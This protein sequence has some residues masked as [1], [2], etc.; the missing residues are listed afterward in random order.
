[1]KQQK[2]DLQN[3]YLLGGFL[4]QG[5]MMGLKRKELAEL[6]K[7][8][9]C[10][11]GVCPPRAQRPATS[12]QGQPQRAP[13]MYDFQ[14]KAAPGQTPAHGQGR[15][16][17]GGIAASSLGENAQ[18]QQ[19][20]KR[21]NSTPTPTLPSPQQTDAGREVFTSEGRLVYPQGGGD[22]Y[23]VKGFQPAAQTQSN[24]ISQVNRPRAP[25][26]PLN[27]AQQPQASPQQAPMQAGPAGNSGGYQKLRGWLPPQMEQELNRVGWG[28]PQAAQMIQSFMQKNPQLQKTSEESYLG[29]AREE[30]L[31]LARVHNVDAQDYILEVTGS[32]A[33]FEK[34]A[35]L[36][37]HRVFHGFVDSMKEHGANSDFV[38]GF[39]KEAQD[40]GFKPMDLSKPMT[41]TMAG[42][43]GLGLG[44][45]T[46][47]PNVAPLGG[48]LGAPVS[49]S[50]PA[51]Q[52][53]QSQPT[54]Q[55]QQN[56]PAPQSSDEPIPNTMPRFNDPPAKESRHEII[57][58]F[59]N[60][61]TGGL[62]GMLLGSFIG[63]EM[64]LDGPMGML[65][66]LLGAGAGYH[67]LPKLMNKWKDPAGTGANAIHP[68]V[69]NMNQQF[70]HSL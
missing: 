4:K 63:N 40:N 68:A 61:W 28:T 20:I 53:Q 16:Y 12:N 5:E 6:L 31:K 69:Q 13:S 1:M 65:L 36:E 30:M 25:Y 27:P 35:A 41:N 18:M 7:N 21:M 39:M 54:A 29:Y 9:S 32:A 22:P 59:N 23:F 70:G 58:G 2:L 17:G 3:P 24:N 37:A 8:A 44:T 60:K 15:S 48:Q 49:L 47:A 51:P 14:T 19:Q 45:G 55:P 11:G 42:D 43:A 46:S 52:A 62:G 26:I 64:G 57:P 10:R 56:Q 38:Q 67:Y 34:A 66:P 33:A 50:A